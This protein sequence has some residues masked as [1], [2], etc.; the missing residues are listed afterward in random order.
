MDIDDSLQALFTSEIVQ[1]DGDYYVRVPDGEVDL[2][3]LQRGDT[4]RVGITDGIDT[5]NARS[6]E[7]QKGRR[8][9]RSSRRKGQS[10]DAPVDEGDHYDVEV[11]DTGEQGDG[12]THID[13]FVIIIPG[14]KEGDELRIEIQKVLDSF[15]IAEPVEDDSNAESDDTAEAV[16]AGSD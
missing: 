3:Q 8:R 12:I 2:G 7:V 6:Q 10:N 5:S 4:V 16:A 14:A 15:A 11:K 13:G 9:D 1:I